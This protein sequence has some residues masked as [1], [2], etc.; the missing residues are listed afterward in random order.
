MGLSKEQVDLECARAEAAIESG[1]LAA[2]RRSS[3][4]KEAS[5]VQARDAFAHGEGSYDTL[6]SQRLVER[7]ARELYLP[8]KDEMSARKRDVYFW[9]KVASAAKSCSNAARSRAGRQPGPATLTKATW[10]N[11][12][13]EERTDHLDIS[14]LLTNSW[15]QRRIVTYAGTDYGVAKMSETVA[16][17]GLEIE[18]HLNLYD[19]LQGEP[20]E[21]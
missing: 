19:V 7:E 14:G 17:T 10:E 18:H 9:K 21:F 1:D 4:A 12:T 13:L 8:L 5:R 11:R 20:S 16:L 6:K 15:E 2:A 3:E